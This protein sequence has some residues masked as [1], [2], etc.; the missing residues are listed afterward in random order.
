MILRTFP[1]MKVYL[2]PSKVTD[3]AACLDWHAPQSG[4]SIAKR[5]SCATL[6]PRQFSHSRIAFKVISPEEPQQLQIRRSSKSSFVGSPRSFG[7]MRRIMTRSLRLLT[8]PMLVS[9]HSPHSASGRHVTWSIGADQR[10][11]ARVGPT[12]RRPFRGCA[13]SSPHRPL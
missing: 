11:Q 13:L 3:C 2:R 10:G 7:N 12:C 6:S 5:C 1:D 8:G 9:R 4:T